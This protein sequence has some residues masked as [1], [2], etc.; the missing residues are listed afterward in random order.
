MRQTTSDAQN[1][2]SERLPNR[3]QGLDA[4]GNPE[5][6]HEPNAPKD[7]PVV[8]RVAADVAQNIEQE[9]EPRPRA[10][11]RGRLLFAGYLVVLIAVSALALAAHTFSVL[12]GD[13]PFTRELQETKN[14]AITSTMI[15]I[16]YIGYPVQSA[17]L[18]AVAVVILWAIRLRLEAIFMVISLLGDALA[19]VLK[20]VVG[21]H[22]PQPDLVHV[23]QHLSDGSF[24]SGHT[25]HYTI[26]Y[27][28]L[29]FIVAS[30][31]RPSWRRTVVLVI[32]AIPLA[33]VG[34][35]RVY[36]G[37][38]WVTDVVGGYLIGALFL[39]LL[40]YAYLWVK[41]RYVI[42]TRRPFVRRA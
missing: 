34:L 35:S 5:D 30:N 41:Q 9:R 26:F 1:A 21:R 13:L 40:C 15:F 25:L 4:E 17:I 8:Q 2:D 11:Y 14:P 16:S 28:F 37:E 27:G 18:L 3:S 33:L 10:I 31:F 12:P 23:V 39:V 24:P 19:G 32:L 38:H 6:T 29:I 42:A 20:A 7:E 36:L 22:R